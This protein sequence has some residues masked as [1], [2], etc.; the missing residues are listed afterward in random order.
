MTSAKVTRG[1]SQRSRLTT[2]I[3]LR[4]ARDRESH[5]GV[6]MKGALVFEGGRPAK[7]KEG[8]RDSRRPRLAPLSPLRL[9]VPPAEPA[10]LAVT[11]PW[12]L[13]FL[14]RCFACENC[15]ALR[16]SLPFLPPSRSLRFRRQDLHGISTRG[17]SA[18]GKE[19]SRRQPTP[20]SSPNFPGN[21]YIFSRRK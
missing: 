9:R 21:L 12:L 18:G 16:R 10:I 17:G 20:K 6:D 13:G 5:R 2:A 11:H 3:G 19:S 15:E 1:R 8:M 4:P 7:G 14:E